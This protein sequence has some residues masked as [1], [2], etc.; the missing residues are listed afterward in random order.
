MPIKVFL[1]SPNYHFQVLTLPYMRTLLLPV[2]KYRTFELPWASCPSQVNLVFC[3]WQSLMHPYDA[4]LT[5]KLYKYLLSVSYVQ[6]TF[7][8]SGKTMVM[9]EMLFCSS[10]VDIPVRN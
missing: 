4:V 8:G 10:E 3:L 2:V 5:L 9:K 7:L 1:V 6:G